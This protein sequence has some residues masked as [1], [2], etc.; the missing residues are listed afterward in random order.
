MKA[1]PYIAARVLGTPLIVEPA[2][3]GVILSVLGLRIGIAAQ[4]ELPALPVGRPRRNP[5]MTPEGIAV[6]PVIG[7]LVK[8]VGP[9][10]GA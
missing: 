1:L 8:R 2:R 4:K 7:T 3:L 6:V 9:V 10:E 5:A